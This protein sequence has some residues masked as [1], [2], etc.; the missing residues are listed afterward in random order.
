MNSCDRNRI[1]K[2]FIFRHDA[3]PPEMLADHHKCYCNKVKKKSDKIFCQNCHSLLHTSC[4]NIDEITVTTFE[5]F[6]D[7]IIYLCNKCKT[8]RNE[9]CL[10][11]INN[12]KEELLSINSTQTNLTTITKELQKM[13]ETIST[14]GNVLLETYNNHLIIPNSDTKSKIISYADI[15]KSN[16]NHDSINVNKQHGFFKKSSNMS[17]FEKNFDLNKCIVIS[18]VND[19]KAIS[20]E[21]VRANLALKINGLK[22]MHSKLS[23]NNNLF[24]YCFDVDSYILLQESTHLFFNSINKPMTY[25]TF[26]DDIKS[27]KI[28]VPNINKQ[29]S[30]NTIKDELNIY[31]KKNFN[32][33]DEHIEKCNTNINIIRL[34]KNGTDLNSVLLIIKDEALF[35]YLLIHGISICHLFYAVSIFISKPLVRFCKNCLNYGHSVSKC[36]SNKKTICSNCLGDHLNENCNSDTPLCLH[37]NS[38]S[39]P[40]GSVLC[41]TY[42]IVYNKLKINDASNY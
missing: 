9:L 28:F 25:K 27:F 41:S 24:I 7:S 6:S 34:K 11:S 14:V 22:V 26:L 33:T 3:D 1:L 30:I 16:I 17:Q 19:K 32:Q 10:I 4:E 29:I 35:N 15:A 2:K 39:H 38:V 13:T 21:Y 23:Y 20:F 37:C 36:V 31:I 12:H 5:K 18:H 42:Q 8:G 40:S